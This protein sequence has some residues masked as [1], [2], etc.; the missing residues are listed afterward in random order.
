[1]LFNWLRK[2]KKAVHS[3]LNWREEIQLHKAAKEFF[4]A[5]HLTKLPKMKDLSD[6]YTRIL[7]E[8]RK[9]YAEYKEAKA[10]MQDYLI[11]RQNLET[12]LG[13]EKKEKEERNAR[14]L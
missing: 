5:H 12:V 2:T 13:A 1:M 10:N 14:E 11:A 8:K 6:E 4:D 9:D 3:Q 7:E